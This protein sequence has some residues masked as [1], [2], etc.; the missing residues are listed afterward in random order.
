MAAWVHRVAAVAVRRAVVTPRLAQDVREA[1][2]STAR[3]EATPSEH[4]ANAEPVVVQP[5]PL[6]EQLAAMWY[7]ASRAALRAPRLTTLLR[8][9]PAFIV[10]LRPVPHPGRVALPHTRVQPVVAVAALAAPRVEYSPV[11][12]VAVAA[13]P[14]AA[15]VVEASLEAAAVA[16]EAAEEDN[17]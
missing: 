17:A 6:A 9:L 7:V 2:V 14:V 13:S 11:A 4:V 15:A 5:V 3:E 10:V 16:A 12:A 8:V 1:R